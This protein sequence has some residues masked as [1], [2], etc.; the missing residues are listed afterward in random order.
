MAFAVVAGR[1]EF[2]RGSPGPT[3]GETESDR[4]RYE[5]LR[6]DG[7]HQPLTGSAGV[8]GIGS[9]RAGQLVLAG[10]TRCVRLYPLLVYQVDDLEQDRIGFLN[11][12]AIRQPGASTSEGGAEYL[13]YLSGDRLQAEDA[14]AELATWLQR[15]AEGVD[16]SGD[17]PEIRPAARAS[18]TGTP[19]SLVGVR[20]EDALESG[21]PASDP[22]GKRAATPAA[23]TTLTAA[24]GQNALQ[25]W[26]ASGDWTAPFRADPTSARL[27]PSAEA[28]VGLMASDGAAAAGNSPGPR[29]ADAAGGSARPA[30]APGDPAAKQGPSVETEPADPSRAGGVPVDASAP[31][32]SS[33]GTGKR[34]APA[35]TPA[36]RIGDFE[37]LGELGRGGWAVVYKARQASLGRIVALKVL[38]PG[39]SADAAAVARFRREIAALGRCD[40]PGVVKVLTAGQDGERTYYAME[41]VQGCDLGAAYRVLR[42]WKGPSDGRLREGHLLEAVSI[43]GRGAGG[44]TGVRGT[45][46]E[47]KGPEPAPP[48]PQ[49][50]GGR[51][52]YARIAEI[53]ADAA[54][55]VHHLHQN[56]ILHR[57]SEAQ[58]HLSDRG[59]QTS[60]D[61]GPGT[62]AA[63]G[64]DA[65]YRQPIG[66]SCGHP[67]LHVAGAASTEPAGRHPSDG[68]VFPWSHTAGNGRAGAAVRRGLRGTADPPDPGP[69]NRRRRRSGM[70]PRPTR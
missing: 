23:R 11:R 3:G 29:P 43:A 61:H 62:G 9:P 35:V 50:Q 2:E 56:G 68:C 12:A 28:S 51:D 38:D 5:L 65:G 13:D 26:T 41:Y 36:V 17:A 55:A 45:R 33:A 67:A 58:Q 16:R 1:G 60:G 59:W 21:A 34:T 30:A 8:Q 52:Y 69:K 31:P 57:D 27:D 42:A 64:P 70:R 53:V 48:L 15:L 32:G 19:S 4:I 40:H 37:L 47:A 49:L 66:Q 14:G 18:K 22:P 25:S 24:I 39:R 63:D 6:G 44:S 54:R 20:S 10:R 46:A 7:I